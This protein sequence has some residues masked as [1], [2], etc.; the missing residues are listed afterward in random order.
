MGDHPGAANASW[1][2]IRR[3]ARVGYQGEAMGLTPRS[4][5][6][7]RIARLQARLAAVDDA[8]A[9]FVLQNADLFYFTGTVQDAW[10]VIPREGAPLLLVRKSLERA[11]AESPLP[12]ILPIETPREIPALLAGHGLGKLRRVGLEFDALP[13]QQYIRIGRVFP[14]MQFV[15][16][17]MQIREVRMIK[18]PHEVDI[19]R[20]AALIQDHMARRLREVLR[21][22][23][24]ELEVAAEIEAEARRYGH[25]GLVR[26][27]RF[28][29]ECHYGHL[30]SGEGASAPIFMDS[31]NGGN[32]L[33]PAFGSG[34]A[35]LRRINPNEPIL[36][37]YVGVVDGYHSD[38]TRL[39]ALGGLPDDLVK[40]YEACLAIRQEVLAHLRPGMKSGEVYAHAAGLAE[41]LGYGEGFMNAGAAQVSFV[42]H[43]VG[44][45]LDELPLLADGARQT[46]EVGMTIAVEPKIV[47][48]GRGMVGVEDT[49]LVTPSGPECLTV[50]P[51]DLVIL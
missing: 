50:T 29:Q 42:G 8:E 46:I 4:E 15:D 38:Q 26:M 23:M 25:Q 16:A 19:M 20:R 34:G 37:D 22:G 48:P 27:R 45:E 44:I 6:D 17:S 3:G 35:S 7:T 43:G 18:S 39:F 49:I 33:S 47:F 28:N 41:R 32:G 51:R 13:V 11:R 40:G 2:H 24:T 21:A 10:L 14:S 30:M 36:L 1:L 5:I 9:V 31:P 12:H